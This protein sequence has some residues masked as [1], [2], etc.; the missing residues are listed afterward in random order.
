[1]LGSTKGL[2]AVGGQTSQVDA[3]EPRTP[4]PD[5]AVRRLC[6]AYRPQGYTDPA[7]YPEREGDVRRAHVDQK[8][9]RFTVDPAVGYI[10]TEPVALQDYLGM[11]LGIPDCFEVP[12]R[13]LPI[14]EQA[15]KE[16]R[17]YGQSDDPSRE[18]HDLAEL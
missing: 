6:H 7:R 17:E 18:Q 14:A 11:A 2:H 1:M 10:V 13:V 5:V 3:A 9:D 8:D 4:G 15:L 12:V 16:Q